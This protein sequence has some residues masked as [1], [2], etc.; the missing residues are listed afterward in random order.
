MSYTIHLLKTMEEPVD[1]SKAPRRGRC[2]EHIQCSAFDL[3]I[4]PHTQGYHQEVVCNG[5][6][7]SA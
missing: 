2:P 1:L 7:L 5:K 6:S 3:D 4:H